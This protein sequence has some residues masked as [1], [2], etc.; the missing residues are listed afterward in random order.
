MSDKST[1][2]GSPNILFLESELISRWLASGARV[3]CPIAD[4]FI[5]HHGALGSF[6]RIH[7]TGEVADVGELV[8]FCD[9]LPQVE[10][11]RTGEM[12][13][14]LFEMPVDRGDD[15]V[16]FSKKSAVIGGNG[17]FSDQETPLIRL[18]PLSHLAVFNLAPGGIW[19]DRSYTSKYSTFIMLEV[20]IIFGIEPM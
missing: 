16:V 6:V 10:A 19:P 20:L 12:T 4:P 13:A 5:R 17:G 1:K 15:L 8:K 11:A 3:I 18:I 7:I 14:A 9:S 2:D